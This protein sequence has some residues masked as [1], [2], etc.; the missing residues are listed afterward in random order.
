MAVETQIDAS[1][2]LA[3][4][5][6][7]RQLLTDQLPVGYQYHSLAHTEQVVSAAKEIGR[8]EKL[9]EHELNLLTLASW[10]HDIGY[11]QRYVGHED[12]SIE[13]AT[14]FFRNQQADEALIE[15]I[16]KLINATRL[17]VEPDNL[18]EAVLKD[19]D[20]YNLSTPNALENSRMIRNEW[21]IFCARDFT[22]EEWDRFNYRFFKDH[23]YLTTYG[24][25]V[26]EPE[27]KLNTKQLKKLVKRWDNL[28]TQTLFLSPGSGA[29]GEA[30]TV[31][32]QQRMLLELKLEQQDNELDKLKRKL[33][34][35]KKDRSDRPDRGIETMFRTTYRTHIN[36]SD[37]A[38]NKANIL[39][40]INAIIISIV[41]TEAFS[42]K[43]DFEPYMIYCGFGLMAV[44]M[45]TIVF[46]ILATRPKV[47]EGV[48]DR[49]DILQ[50]KTNLLFFGNFHNMDLEDFQWGINQMMNDAEYLYG[51]MSKDIYFLGKV[52]ARKFSLLRIAYNVF[53]Y[54][55]GAVVLAIFVSYM[56]WG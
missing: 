50:K 21:K 40:S 6:Y 23:N 51:S 22:D 9:S 53:M 20:L 47:N 10:V 30:A 33:K 31:N 7:V 16:N 3:T 38:D 42:N 8:F 24:R 52:L 27:K 43:L 14:A 32:S 34:K 55:M 25:D 17:E 12:A 56:I 29:N 5:Q 2:L 39:L 13:L 46:A 4:E 37:L 15:Q 45:T 26:L 44:C 18:M 41:L 49:E 48:F 54:G 36:L 11:V 19:A 1:L 35:F 28:R